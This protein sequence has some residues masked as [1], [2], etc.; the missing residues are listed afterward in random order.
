M[1]IYIYILIVLYYIHTVHIMYDHFLL[2]AYTHLPSQQ[3]SI[4]IYIYRANKCE[5]HTHGQS[6]LRHFSMPEQRLCCFFAWHIY[7]FAISRPLLFLQ[8]AHCQQLVKAVFIHMFKMQLSSVVHVSQFKRLLLVCYTSDFDQSSYEK[9]WAQVHPALQRQC[10]S[11]A[12]EWA[13]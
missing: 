13:S 11:V 12:G 8:D 4:Y 10:S 1:C 6:I 9:R 2:Y 5:L 3:C 7:A